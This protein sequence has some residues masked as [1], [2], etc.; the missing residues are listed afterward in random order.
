MTDIARRALVTGGAGFIGSHLTEALI[1][2]GYFVIVADNLLTGRKENLALLDADSY[3][4]VNWDIVLPMPEELEGELTNL[5]YIFH[6]ASPASPSEH[7]PLSYLHYPEETALANTVGT[8]RLLQLAEKTEANFVF[9]STSEI[10]GDPEVHPQPETYT[11][12]ADSLSSRACYHEAKRMGETWVKIFADHARADGRIVRI[13]NTY[14]PRAHP[15]DGR[16]ISNF[17]MQ[18][19]REEPITVYGDG[20]QTR[21]YCY[22]ADLIS[23]LLKVA[24][25]QDATGKVYNLGRPEEYSII[26][27]AEI[28]QAATGSDSEIVFRDRPEDDPNRR[29]PDITKA[30]EELNWLPQIDFE[31]GIKKTVAYYRTLV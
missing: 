22:V 17:I 25:Y 16:V 9:A 20:K 30:K 3:R 10:Y 8:Y 31:S 24:E 2:R 21:S 13:F 15:N 5:T 4:F 11:G 26:E 23:G 28:I 18:A 14:G 6:L 19:L 12:K 27:T 1:D 7:S 29:R